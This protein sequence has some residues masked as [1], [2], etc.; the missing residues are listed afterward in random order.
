[1][2]SIGKQSIP[3]AVD[4]KHVAALLSQQPGPV[5][6]WFAPH[7]EGGAEN[8][9]PRERVE[10]AGPVARRWLAKTDNFLDQ[11][12]P[13]PADSFAV[14]LPPHW[15]SPFWLLAPWMRGLELRTDR[16][17]TG[18]DLLISNDTDFLAS[19]EAQGGPSALVA[20]TQDSFAL[21]WPG[22]LPP[23]FTDGVADILSYGDE[24]DFP[25]TAP[26]DSLLVE[27]AVDWVPPG[28]WQDT[29]KV[30]LH[31]KD[32][33]TKNYLGLD[34]SSL[35]GGRVLVATD[36]LVLAAAQILQ[37]WLAEASVVWVPGG[38]NADQIAQ[39][40]LVTH[41]AQVN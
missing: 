8:D 36:N 5:L 30:D 37:S 17:A 4:A 3:H 19:I 24:V 23:T 2:N 38:Y 12:F 35:T 6:T 10:L 9:G 7:D 41:R 29:T 15:R 16:Q 25:V 22:D 39:D 21:A 14:L 33:A 26:A 34:R 28:L 20:Q 11:E 13:Y 40:E 31:L 18:V 27:R 1:M 32:L